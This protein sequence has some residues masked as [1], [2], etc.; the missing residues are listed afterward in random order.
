MLRPVRFGLATLVAVGLLGSEDFASATTLSFSGYIDEV[1]DPN[2]FL[3]PAVVLGAEFTAEFEIL[4][5]GFMAPVMGVPGFVYYGSF[6]FDPFP[7]QVPGVAVSVAIGGEELSS[8][9]AGFGIGNDMSS[10]TSSSVDLWTTTQ[11]SSLHPAPGT[12][13]Y[14]VT[15]IDS[16]GLKLDDTSIFVPSDS[17]LAGWDSVRFWMTEPGIFCDDP[18][19]CLLAAGT[20]SAV[21]I[22]EPATAMILALG[23]VGLAFRSKTPQKPH[24]AVEDTAELGVTSR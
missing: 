10:T 12:V 16:S 18:N 14:G 11:P 15:F 21:V 17:N 4:L 6:L 1:N 20:I 7:N 9:W 13:M 2:G 24:L 19:Q 22:P 23:L 5:L 8:T 3:D